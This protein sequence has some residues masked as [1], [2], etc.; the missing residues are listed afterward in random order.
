MPTRASLSALVGYSELLSVLTTRMAEPMCGKRKGLSDLS[1]YVNVR[2]HEAVGRR[3][4][5]ERTR[6]EQTE[7]FG[8]RADVIMFQ[9]FRRIS[10]DH[11]GACPFTRFYWS[12]MVDEENGFRKR[13]PKGNHGEGDWQGSCPLYLQKHSVVFT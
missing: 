10:L 9:R 6:L 7:V 8:W 1:S 5:E 3:V 13:S 12:V 2:G 11:D 4:V